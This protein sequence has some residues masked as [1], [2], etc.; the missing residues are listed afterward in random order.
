MSVCVCVCVFATF[1]KQQFIVTL[2][3]FTCLNV[4]Y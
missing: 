3:P 1:H 2:L 4:K